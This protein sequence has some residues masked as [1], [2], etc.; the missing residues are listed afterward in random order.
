M[1]REKVNTQTDGQLAMTKARWPMASGA[2]NSRRRIELYN[3]RVKDGRQQGEPE[4]SSNVTVVSDSRSVYP[5][6]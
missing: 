5:T 1:F 3:P 4:N 6:V 2:K